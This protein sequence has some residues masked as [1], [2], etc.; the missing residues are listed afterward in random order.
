MTAPMRIRQKIRLITASS[1]NTRLNSWKEI[2]AYLGRDARTVQLWEKQEELPIHRHT[3]QAR[4]SVYAYSAEL[5]A[6]LKMR[7]AE[8]AVRGAPQTHGDEEL[9]TARVSGMLWRLGA[10]VLLL[11]ILGTGFW[12]VINRKTQPKLPTGALAVLPFENLSPSEDL[13]VD[14]LTDVLITDLGRAGQIQVISRRSAMQFKG[15]HLPLPQIA[16]KLHASLVLEGTVTRSGN[17]IRV[18]AQ[19]LDAVQD[20]PI[21]AASY[22][23]KTNDVIA[24]QDEIAA[25]IASEVTQKLTGTVPPASPASKSVDPRARLAYLTGRHFWEQRDEPGLRKAVAYFQQ[26]ATID[27]HYAPAYAGLADSYNLMAGW[28]VPPS[29]ESFSRAKA[30]AQTA[31]SLDPT[32]AE[33]YNSLAFAT[34][35]QDWDFNRADQYFRRAIELNPNYAVAHQWYGEFLGDM[36]RFDQSIAELLKAR[37]LDPLSAM[38]GCDLAEGYL[39]AGRIAEAEAELKRVLNLYQ[40]FAP[41]HAYLVGVYSKQS[42]FAAAES[43]A[44]AY[45]RHTGEESPLQMVRIQ[46]EAATGSVDQA[47]RDVSLLLSGK[48]RSSFSSYQKAQFFFASGQKEAGY[49]ALEEAYRERSWWLVTMLVDPGFDSVRNEHRFHDLAKRVGLPV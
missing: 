45:F 13:L 34:Y 33:A 41:A 26:A 47:R 6:W 12:F 1:P 46:R 25:T 22:S 30:A 14:G 11:G 28:R 44:Q 20:R 42:N 49:A 8:K 16:A 32:S 2:A 38:V 29:G 40:D 3:H 39:H 24:F 21:W 9:R 19:L 23:R 17:D 7:T 36:R 27:P 35:R 43:E 48:S 4:A 37:E 5:D 18:T 10:V 15:Q 31:L